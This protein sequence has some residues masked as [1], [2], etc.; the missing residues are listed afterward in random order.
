MSV[1]SDAHIC[2]AG[3]ETELAFLFACEADVLIRV[4]LVAI[5]G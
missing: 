5:Q 2:H 1:M 4:V 3:Y